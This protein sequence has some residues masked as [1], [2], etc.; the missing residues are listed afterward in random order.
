MFNPE[1]EVIFHHGNIKD[2]RFGVSYFKTFSVVLNALD[3]VDA[4]RHVNRLCLAADVFLIDSGTTG[5]N[6]QI[7]PIK[8]GV[9]ACYECNPKPTQKVYPICTIRSTPDKPV[10]CIV[11]AKE[12]FKLLFGNPSDSMLFEDPNCEEKSLYM[13]LVTQPAAS[14]SLDDFV[15]QGCALLTAIYDDEIRAKIAMDVYKTAKC[16]PKPLHVDVFQK[17]S[18]LVH[19]VKSGASSR[20]SRQT[21]W[22]QAKW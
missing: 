16:V 6:G 15:Q 14:A 13:H 21:G 20:P 4:R 12:F 22:D 18:A 17:A 8:R 19:Q 10:H 1:S 2:S 11:W 5:Y 9:S 3:N 7:M